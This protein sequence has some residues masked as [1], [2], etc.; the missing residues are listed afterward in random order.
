MKETSNKPV[1]RCY[2][3]KYREAFKEGEALF[4]V[5][6]DLNLKCKYS[7]SML[8]LTEK[9]LTAFDECY[10]GGSMTLGFSEIEHAEVKRLYGNAFFKVKLKN[11]KNKTCCVFHTRQQRLPMP[12]Q[13]L[14][15]T[16][17]A[18]SPLRMRQR[19]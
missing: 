19:S 18:V 6:G 4:I 16:Q 8:V 2:E 1:P 15:T 12:A 9:S 3:E 13:C 17:T 7:D 5:V 11:G 14:S 10:E